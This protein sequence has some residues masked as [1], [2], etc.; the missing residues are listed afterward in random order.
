MNKPVVFRDLLPS[1]IQEL[2]WSGGPRHLEYLLDALNKGKDK[3]EFVCAVIDDSVIGYG[4]IDFEKNTKGG[5]LTMFVIK[6]QYRSMGIGTKLFNEAHKRIRQRGLS[7]S[8]LSVEKKNPDAKRLYERMGYKVIRQSVEQ[9]EQD[10][11]DGVELYS[12][13][14]DVMKLELADNL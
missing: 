9:W 8:E 6:E 5:Y 10:T 13:E 11:A 14:V 7:L 12:S 4:G 3:F 2:S 1:D